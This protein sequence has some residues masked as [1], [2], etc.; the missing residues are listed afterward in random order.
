MVA[1]RTA[2]DCARGCGVSLCWAQE[3][4]RLRAATWKKSVLTVDPSPWTMAT[5]RDQRGMTA[6]SSLE[7][8]CTFGLNTPRKERGE[9]WQTEPASA[10]SLVMA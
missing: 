10:K 1:S 3:S 4:L 5:N 6:R 8:S 2:V 7:K 9:G